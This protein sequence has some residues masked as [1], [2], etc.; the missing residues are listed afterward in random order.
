MT[1]LNII[2]LLCIWITLYMLYLGIQFG[3]LHD[4]IREFRKEQKPTQIIYQNHTPMSQE[5][6]V[7]NK[8]KILSELQKHRFGIPSVPAGSCFCKGTEGLYIQQKCGECSK[9]ITMVH[10]STQC[11]WHHVDTGLTLCNSHQSMSKM[12]VPGGPRD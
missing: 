6:R 10:G 9:A 3:R 7:L 12:A 5:E 1:T 4:E 11:R 2:L 8:Q